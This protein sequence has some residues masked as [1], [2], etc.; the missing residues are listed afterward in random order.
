MTLIR[1]CS[2]F[3]KPGTRFCS[4]RM[5]FTEGATRWVMRKD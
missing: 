5:K 1:N 2:M 3:Q 4:T